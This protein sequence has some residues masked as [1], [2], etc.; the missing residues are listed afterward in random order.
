MLVHR[1]HLEDQPHI[2]YQDGNS[3]YY[4]TLRKVDVEYPTKVTLYIYKS[5]LNLGSQYYDNA[6]NEYTKVDLPQFRSPTNNGLPMFGFPRYT[7]TMGRED[8]TFMRDTYTPDMRGMGTRK[9]VALRLTQSYQSH[10]NRG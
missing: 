5:P 4:T 9:A 8:N 3:Q 7:N 1:V 6:D 10:M 2:L